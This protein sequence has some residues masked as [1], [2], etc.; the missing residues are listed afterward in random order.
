M[1]KEEIFKDF[2]EWSPEHAEMTCSYRQWGENSI[3]IWLVNGYIYKCK[4]YAP[5]RFVMQQLSE[6]DVKR[7]YN[8][9]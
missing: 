5:H 9:K 7:K 6:D 1:T 4:C 8:L 3:A 2:C